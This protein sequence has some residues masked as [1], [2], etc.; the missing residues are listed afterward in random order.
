MSCP[1]NLFSLERSVGC[2]EGEGRAEG[3]L[4]LELVKAERDLEAAG[5]LGCSLPFL[6]FRPFPPF[7]RFAGPPMVSFI[8]HFIVNFLGNLI[9]FL[10]LLHPG[11]AGQSHACK[12]SLRLLLNKTSLCGIPTCHL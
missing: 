4:L 12:E 3:E 7:P 11:G 5:R 6:P 2:G 9:C 1:S 8:L 10:Q